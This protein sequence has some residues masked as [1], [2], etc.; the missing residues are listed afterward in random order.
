MCLCQVGVAQKLKIEISIARVIHDISSLFFCTNSNCSTSGL[1]ASVYKLYKKVKYALAPM[2]RRDQ[3][4][5]YCKCLSSTLHSVV[6]HLQPLMAR[7]RKR[8]HP[9][10]A[11]ETTVI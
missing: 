3:M 6:F 8:C 11:R 2:E 4:R 10:L 5:W 7:D 9:L 1:A